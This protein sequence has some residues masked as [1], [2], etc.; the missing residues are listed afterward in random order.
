MRAAKTSLDDLRRE[1]DEIDDALLGE[2]LAFESADGNRN[3]I[4][5]LLAFRRRDRDFLDQRIVLRN[6]EGRRTA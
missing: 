2:I 3:F 1:I 5:A 4:N 6:G